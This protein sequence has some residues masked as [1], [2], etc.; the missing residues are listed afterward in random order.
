MAVVL[1]LAL[2][3][4]TVPVSAQDGG[5]ENFVGSN[6]AFDV[7][8]NS[9]ADYRLGNTEVFTELKVGSSSES[10]SDGGD[11]GVGAGAGV[12]VSA[13]SNLSAVTSMTG[14]SVSMSARAKTKATVGT[15]GSAEIEAHDDPR[16]ILV[17]KDGGETS[18]Y[19]LT[20]R[21]AV[22]LKP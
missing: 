14:A 7:H 8:S 4:V 6:I 10:D 1:M 11:M 15:E 17:V 21:A 22:K 16:G 3:A 19:L 9:I 18:P 20:Y 12:A 5:S 13:G 2:T